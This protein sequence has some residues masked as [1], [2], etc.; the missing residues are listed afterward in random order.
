VAAGCNLHGLYDVSTDSDKPPKNTICEDF[1]I[2]C[3]LAVQH[4]VIPPAWDWPKFLKT[5]V[6]LLPYAFEK[7]DAQE[8][9]GGENVFTAMTGGR[10]LRFTGEVFYG[11]SIRGAAGGGGV[12]GG[13]DHGKA[14]KTLSKQVEGKWK[15]LV[16][17]GGDMFADVGGVA[18]WKQLHSALQLHQPAY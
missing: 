11:S 18:L 14:F 13:G 2:F 12:A 3:K 16:K 6:G 1:L 5:A 4:K 17:G 15:Q 7:S 8:K 10:S 9:W